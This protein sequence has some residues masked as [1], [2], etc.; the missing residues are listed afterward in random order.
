M[1]TRDRGHEHELTVAKSYRDSTNPGVL[2]VATSFFAHSR[3]VFA[4][5]VCSFLQS[6]SAIVVQEGERR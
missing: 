6:N 1:W 3:N 4:A 2:R 5:R